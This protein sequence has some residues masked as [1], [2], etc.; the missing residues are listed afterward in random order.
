MLKIDVPLISL[1]MRT[2]LTINY[3]LE[4][5]ILDEGILWTLGDSFSNPKISLGAKVLSNYIN[6]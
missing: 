2:S 1:P 5:F 3:K 6:P 4:R